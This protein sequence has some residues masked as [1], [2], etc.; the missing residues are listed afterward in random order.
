[1]TSEEEGLHVSYISTLLKEHNIKHVHHKKARKIWIFT[2]DD[3][4]IFICPIGEKTLSFD[5]T[6]HNS[7]SSLRFDDLSNPKAYLWLIEMIKS[8]IRYEELRKEYHR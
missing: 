5:Y 6:H 3:H 2:Q 7:I 4:L 8:I 1:M